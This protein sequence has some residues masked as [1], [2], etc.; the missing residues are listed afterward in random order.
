MTLN[1]SS[2]KKRYK[3]PETNKDQLVFKHAATQTCRYG[4]FFKASLA[5]RSV[6]QSIIV[7]I[8]HLKLHGLA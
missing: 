7:V 8:K 6:Q 1:Q 2:R 5:I 3:P 4:P